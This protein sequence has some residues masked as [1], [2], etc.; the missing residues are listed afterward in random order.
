MSESPE[1]VPTGSDPGLNLISEVFLLPT[2]RFVGLPKFVLG[3]ALLMSASL[4]SGASVARAV[5]A[6]KMVRK[7]PTAT[8]LPLHSC[9]CFFMYAL[10]LVYQSAAA[11]K[12]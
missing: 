7:S 10:P 12:S 8:A 2:A 5:N 4:S 3:C 1:V 11:R 6:S 9:A